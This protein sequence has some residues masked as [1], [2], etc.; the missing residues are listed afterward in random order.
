MK[1]LMELL[2]C[3]RDDAVLKILDSCFRRNDGVGAR[4]WFDRLTTNE[5]KEAHHE[6][7]KGGSL[8]GVAGGG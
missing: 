2:R 1:L 3:V 7:E 4:W 5:R 8:R 6:R